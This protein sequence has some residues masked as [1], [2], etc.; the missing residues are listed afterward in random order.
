M[1]IFAGEP[2]GLEYLYRQTGKVLI[3]KMPGP[4]STVDEDNIPVEVDEFE[5]TVQED[6]G[7]FEE[8]I[9]VESVS[10]YLNIYNIK[11]YA[12]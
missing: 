6:D 11:L 5:E 1:T 12:M 2:Y 9:F 4:D 3:M 8:T 10:T 7:F